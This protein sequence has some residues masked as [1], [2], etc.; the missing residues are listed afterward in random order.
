M[1]Y[2]D[3]SS[4]QMMLDLDCDFYYVIYSYLRGWSVRLNKKKQETNDVLYGE[5]TELGYGKT[6]PH[7]YKLT[8]LHINLVDVFKNVKPNLMYGG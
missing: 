4:I 7:L 2:K 8:N 3:N 1:N 5:I 6:D